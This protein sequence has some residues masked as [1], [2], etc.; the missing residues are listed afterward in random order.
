MQNKHH[1]L[2][3][4]S[5]LV[6]LLFLVSACG[7]PGGSG[8]GTSTPQSNL[9][10]QQVLQN[11]QKAMSQLKSAHVNLQIKGSGQ[12]SGQA[13]PTTGTPATSGAASFSLTGSGDE[14]LPGQEQ[15]NVTV[16][17]SVTNI[18]I[19]VAEIL[20]GGKLYAQFGGQWYVLNGSS[21]AA[22]PLGGLSSPDMSQLLGLLNH[23]EIVDH[24]DQ[25]LNGTSLRH[26]TFK[27][28]K[29]ALQ[30]LLDSNQ[31]L[32]NM[33][34]KANIDALINN[35]QA[36]NASLDL[37]IDETQFYVHRTELK[38]NLNVNPAGISQSITPMPGS[39]IQGSLPTSVL[40]NLDLIVDLSNFN[41]PVTITPPANATPIGIPTVTA[42]P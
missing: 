9:T 27:L 14:A 37:W 10:A 17:Q 40:A 5:G 16:T 11:S 33:V 1:V 13:S 36:F 30:Q 15:M 19:T 21:G 4:L 41:A 29:F 3:L 25:S 2:C 23:M 12:S 28:D 22:R 34:G 31:Q 26:I 18:P 20:S 8:T 32:V 24:G 39:P 42:T 35:T 7:T 6:A 38:L